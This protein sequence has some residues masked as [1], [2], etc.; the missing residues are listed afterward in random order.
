MTGPVPPFIQELQQWITLQNQNLVKWETSGAGTL[1]ERQVLGSFH[2]LFYQA[3][4]AFYGQYI[5]DPSSSLGNITSGGTL[6]N[7]TAISYALSRKLQDA[8]ATFHEAGLMK[9]LQDTGY[10]RAVVMGTAHCHYSLQKVMRL[11]GL[12]TRAF[13]ALDADELSGAAGSQIL[14]AKIRHLQA[15]GV[16]VIALV[17]VAG[18]TEAGRIDPLE[19]MAEV[20]ARHQVHFHV[21]A[22]FGGAFLFSDQYASKLKGISDADSIT[23]CGHKQLYLPMGTS[24]CLFK[25]P[26]LAKQI[27][28]NSYYQARKGSVDLGK[29]TIEGSRPF[30]ALLFHGA[31]Q[32]IGKEGYAAMVD[33][34]YARTLLFSE[35]IRS[36]SHFQLYRHPDLNIV[37]YRYVPAALREKALAGR[38]NDAE[39]TLLNERNIYLQQEQFRRRESFVSYTEMPDETGKR[40]VWLR[41]VLMNPDTTAQHLEEILQEQLTIMHASEDIKTY[42]SKEYGNQ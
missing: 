16:L 41:S 32:V 33:S 40:H 15:E 27:E 2:R 30:S 3:P 20:A 34:N 35:K 17:G 6:S 10:T 8:G 38:L 29:Y 11:L 12:G 39:R 22:A 31:L 26:G 7:L 37:L 18:T 5:Q 19:M 4:A 36:N 23:L 21:D 28:I 24:L 1:L 9:S 13:V 42:K 14:D 25:S